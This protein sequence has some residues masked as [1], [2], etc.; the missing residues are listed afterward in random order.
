[1][2]SADPQD[3]A[4]AIHEAAHVVAGALEDPAYPYRRV[5]FRALPP[6]TALSIGH[7]ARRRDD[8]ADSERELLSMV[9][10][11][12]KGVLDFKHRRWWSPL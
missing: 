10:A 4:T 3:I 6:N 2:S 5:V 7:H 9:Q 11:L 1:M 8:L 12:P